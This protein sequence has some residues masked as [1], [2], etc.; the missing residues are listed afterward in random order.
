MLS[1]LIYLLDYFS[2]RRR[3]IVFAIFASMISLRAQ[4][5]FRHFFFADYAIIFA[6]FVFTPSLF[7]AESHDAAAT[8]ITTLL[9]IDFHFLLLPLFSLFFFFFI[10]SPCLSSFSRAFDFSIGLPF[11]RFSDAAAM[12]CAISLLLIISSDGCFHFISSLIFFR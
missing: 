10:S 3:F 9:I 11:L 7:A 6:A 4:T 1:S 2:S 12:P 5:R 8:L